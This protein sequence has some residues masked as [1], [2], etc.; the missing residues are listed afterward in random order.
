MAAKKESPKNSL[1]REYNIPLRREWIKVPKYKRAKKAGK[2]LKEF[3]VRN[4]K[5][6]AMDM[7]NVKIGKALNEAIW[8]QGIRSPPHHIKIHAIKDE[9]GIVRADLEGVEIKTEEKKEKKK[10]PTNLKEK[11]EQKLEGKPKKEKKA[12]ETKEEKTKEVEKQEIKEL[13]KESKTSNKQQHAPQQQQK[14]SKVQVRPNAPKS[15]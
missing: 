9:K 4:M 11:I 15:Q 12:E 3:L 7:R 14:V 8:A 5:P 10:A 2:A 6:E 13:Q 1:E